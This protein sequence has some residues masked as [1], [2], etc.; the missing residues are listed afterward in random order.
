MSIDYSSW[1]SSFLSRRDLAEPDHRP[2]YEYQASVD[3][4]DSLRGLLCSSVQPSSFDRAF[5]ACF[6]LFCSEWYRRD[7]LQH[8]G[9]TW[10]PLWNVLTWNLSAT[11]LSR[12]VPSGLERYWSRPV[13]QYESDRRNFLP[14]A[15]DWCLARWRWFQYRAT[16]RELGAVYRMC[17]ESR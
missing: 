14:S 13:S 17:S 15:Y 11:E 5:S 10:E 8:Y 12:I 2:L 6:T 7:Y 4:Y 9:W 16:R 3:E 1:L